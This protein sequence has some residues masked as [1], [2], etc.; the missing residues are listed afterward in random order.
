MPASRFG[1]LYDFLV[2]VGGDGTINEVANGLLTAENAAS[3][4]LGVVN[5]GTGND[6]IRSLGVP[7]DCAAACARL[8]GSGRTW[9]DVGLY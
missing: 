4:V 5:T 6:L 9:I 1:R 8:T 7:E 2:A 3:T